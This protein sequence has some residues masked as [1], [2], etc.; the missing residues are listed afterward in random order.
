MIA[1]STKAGTKIWEVDVDSEANDGPNSTPSVDEERVYGLTH[2]GQLVCINTTNGSILW[3]KH[4]LTDF[5]GKMESGWG[6]SESPII[7]GGN[8][9]CTP[10]GN[11]AVMVALNK[12]TGEHLSSVEMPAVLVTEVMTVLDTPQLSS[13]ELLDASNTYS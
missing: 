3:K 5:K 4:F 2:A 1:L 10:G 13:V 11:S 9:I 6:Y 8:L 7:D 12:K